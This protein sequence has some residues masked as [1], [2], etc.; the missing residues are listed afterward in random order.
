MSTL[1][2]EWDVARR[3]EQT[4]A[5]LAPW[6]PIAI[7]LASTSIA[8]VLRSQ[9]FGGGLT[10]LAWVSAA[11]A[12]A[13]AGARSPDRA[14]IALVFFLPITPYFRYDTWLGQALPSVILAAVLVGVALSSEANWGQLVRDRRRPVSTPVL[15]FAALLG[16][17]T[18][19]V[20]LQRSPLLLNMLGR[21]EVGGFFTSAWPTLRPQTSVPIDRS[22]GFLLGPVAG[23]AL[24][25]LLWRGSLNGRRWLN[26]EHLLAAFILTSALNF[27]VACGQAYVPGFPIPTL[28]ED[29][30][31]AGLFYNPVGLAQLMTLATPVALA[32]SVRPTRIRWIRPLAAV[33][34][35]LVAL[36]FIPIQQRSAHLG[37]TTG[38]TCLLATAWIA[39]TR[40]TGNDLRRISV[41]T[42]LVA[43]LLM[44]GLGGAYLGT[45]QWQRA[46]AAIAQAPTS[47][48]WLGIHER[49]E[50]NRMAFFMVGDKPLGGHGIGGFESA[51]PA[52]YDRHGPLVRRYSH[53]LLNHPLHM[54][55]DMGILGLAA[56]LW[57]FAAFL[58]PVLR[59]VIT[60]TQAGATSAVDLTTV[61]CV[62]AVGTALFLSIW[63]GE[64]LYDPTISFTA[65]MLTAVAAANPTPVASAR[66]AVPLWII[67]ALPL[68][69][70]VMF[71]LGV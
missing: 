69:H 55:V 35:V 41:V 32:L 18:L 14:L 33:T 24:L 19:L 4:L 25:S 29:G 53:S 71:A 21:E 17:S 60:S 50:T 62:S 67:V 38:V 12:A 58:L 65:F 37:V 2:G 20:L 61:G 22:G 51:L 5:Y 70:T 66:G 28:Y 26:R 1:G 68:G 54:L 15:T 13:V 52:Y 48:A 11:T 43:V 59:R 10:A 49:G 45:G 36:L 64:W 16:V 27:G 56:N 3:T 30:P 23:L 47:T 9:E 6:T 44:A 63:T 34:V 57:M 40:K 8:F 46:V 39:V 42:V 31:T 7:L